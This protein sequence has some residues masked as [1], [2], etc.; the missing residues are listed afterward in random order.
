M[1][2]WVQVFVGLIGALGLV[3]IG[4][5]VLAVARNAQR[6]AG[7][8]EEPRLKIKDLG[9]HQHKRSLV[10]RE[11]ILSKD[12]LK[13][14][15]KRYKQ[16]Q[17]EHKNKEG[18]DQPRSRVYVVDFHGDVQASQT[19]LLRE[20]INALMP[21]LR[22]DHDDIVLRLESPG[23][24]VH[25]YGLAASQLLRLRGASRK[26]TICVDKVAASGG[27]MMA[28][29]G[30][31]IVAAPFAIV[32][33]IG[34]LAGVP[35]FNRLIK[36]K[37]IDYYEL[38]AGKFK[39][40]LSPLGDVTDEKVAKLQEQIEDVHELFKAHVQKARPT[41]DLDRVATGEYWHG[42][43]ALELGLVDRLATSDDVIAEALAHADV[44]E[45]LAQEKETLKHKLWGRF[46][47]GVAQVFKASRWAQGPFG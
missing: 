36:D 21:L 26:L 5:G 1:V 39:R 23:G 32:G 43:R 18:A 6:S 3:L 45:I 15:E 10:L 28:C 4:L 41:M 13:A 40:T 46:F 16:E 19:T 42:L 25:G 11:A 38:T 33:S 9:K 20:T 17:K 44:F 22:K 34:V 14:F 24:V 12:D 27:Y 8:D 35:N 47:G 37:K 31:E 7:N 2:E 29:L 30:H